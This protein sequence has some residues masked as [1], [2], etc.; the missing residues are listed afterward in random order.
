[1]LD[2]LLAIVKTPEELAEL[3]KT[4]PYL[5]DYM[6]CA[7]NDKFISFDLPDAKT[8]DYERS[9]AGAFLLSRG[10]SNLLG[11]IFNDKAASVL[12]KKQYTAMMSM[13]YSGEA[14][15]LKAAI[16]KNLVSVYELLTHE[17]ICAALDIV[18]AKE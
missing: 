2:E 8:N 5:R 10:S 3:I 18:D 1:M 16:T 7:V 13:L 4:T 11:V 17:F 15:I 14:A 6:D 12:R 9:L